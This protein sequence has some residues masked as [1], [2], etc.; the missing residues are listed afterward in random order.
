M[1]LNK[2]NASTVE[3]KLLLTAISMLTIMPPYTNTTPTEML[4]KIDKLRK[5]IYPPIP[6][7]LTQPWWG[8][9][10][11]NGSIRAIRFYGRMKMNELKHNAH[12]VSVQ[13]P[14]QA[15]DADDALRQLN[16]IFKERES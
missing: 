1:E 3:G 9:L 14:F 12:I 11:E 6:E 15:V 16:E 4:D 13:G 5:E 10:H 2:I 7:E 8:Y